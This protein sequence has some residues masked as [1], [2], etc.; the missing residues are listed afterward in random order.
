MPTWAPVD[1]RAR[2]Y[3]ADDQWTGGA[4]PSDLYKEVPALVWNQGHPV[5][6]NT[7]AVGL[8]SDQALIS[9]VSVNKK[10]QIL[11]VAIPKTGPVSREKVKLVLLTPR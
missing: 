4:I 10:G 9:A 5:D 11:A 8:P 3:G 2:H 7:V 6:L 1:A